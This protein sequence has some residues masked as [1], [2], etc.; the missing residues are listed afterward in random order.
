[1]A[2]ECPFPDLRKMGCFLALECLLVGFEPLVQLVQEQQVQERQASLQ[3]GLLGL[4]VLRGLL[5][6]PALGPW[7]LAFQPWA[8]PS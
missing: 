1:M 3:R 7:L 8:R 4:L 5:D 6:Q 2:L